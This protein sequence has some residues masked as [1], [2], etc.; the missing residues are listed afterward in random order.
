MG[1]TVAVAGA[2]GL[3]GRTMLRVLEERS[4]PLDSLRVLASA[5][6][7]GSSI[8]ALGGVHIVE[9]LTER[10]FDGV[11]IALFSA[12][13]SVSKIY[14][15]V[16][17]AAGCVAIDNSSAWRMHPHVPLVV[18]EVNPHALYEHHGIIANPNCST[19]QMVVALQ[20]IHKRYGIKRVVVSTYQSVS[21]AGQKGIA[22]LMNE[23]HGKEVHDRISPHQLAFN[24]VFH[25][26]S[27]A[28]GY[29]EEELKMKHE[30]RR[31]MELPGLPIAVTCVRVPV[32]GGHGESVNVETHSPIDAHEVRELLASSDGITV[33]DEP[34]NAHYPTM[35][36]A[37][38]LDD[39]FVGRIRNDDSVEHGIQ[40]WVVSDNVRKGAA[41]NAVQI[42]E[43]LIATNRLGF[44]QH[45]W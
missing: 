43:K 25:S 36:N 35:K 40:M 10:S 15:P 42:A 26:I 44:T 13:G 12:G 27:D 33:I 20:P 3:V 2:S 5:R 32:L 6:S 30:T 14:A 31:I 19:I 28:S 37:D 29:S 38:N 45:M 17:A 1:Y 39:V 11:D 4:F 21:G 24:A 9:E 22:Q 34:M 41:T 8:E 7:A 16:C 23:L 18:P